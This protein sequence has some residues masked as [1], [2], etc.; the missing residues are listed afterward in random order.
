MLSATLAAELAQSQLDGSPRAHDFRDSNDPMHPFTRM[1]LQHTLPPHVFVCPTASQPIASESNKLLE[2]TKPRTSGSPATPMHE[3]QVPAHDP[4]TIDTSLAGGVVKAENNGFQFPI[5]PD[6]DCTPILHAKHQLEY[7]DAC[8]GNGNSNGNGVLL[9][10]DTGADGGCESRVMSTVKR[11]R[12]DVDY[13]L[14]AGRTVMS[15]ANHTAGKRKPQKSV[16]GSQ[17]EISTNPTLLAVQGAVAAGTSLVYGAAAT[18]VKL[19]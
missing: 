15:S 11:K 6:Q 10:G 5:P 14:L 1:L 13:S 3:T 12:A 8:E 16:M 7:D 9:C 2:I 19:Q 4:C 18:D 17:V